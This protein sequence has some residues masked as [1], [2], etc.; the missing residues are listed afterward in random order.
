MCQCTVKVSGQGGKL[1][2]NI[3]GMTMLTARSYFSGSSAELNSAKT[4]GTGQVKVAILCD[5]L[6]LQHVMRPHF[7]PGHIFSISFELLGTGMDK[8]APSNPF[9]DP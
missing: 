9:Q 2:A 7:L 4:D 3:L 6:A 8:P 1:V 5:V